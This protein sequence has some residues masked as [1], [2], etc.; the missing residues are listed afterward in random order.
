MAR[1]RVITADELCLNPRG[2]RC[3]RCVE[4]CPA[5]AVSLDAEGAPSVDDEACTG[6]G[7][8][9]GV[10]DA[11]APVRVTL[12][13]LRERLAR[14]A[15][16]GEEPVVACEP[17]VEALDGEP[18]P[19]VAVV[20]CL[21]A[22]PAELWAQVLAEG[23]EP[24]A[25]CDFE[26]CDACPRAGEVAVALYA[27]AIEQAQEWTGREVRVRSTVPAETSLVERIVSPEETDRRGYLAG[28]VRGVAD[29]A[30][31]D[32]RRRRSDALQDFYARRER[33]RATA[34]VLRPPDVPRPNRFCA[35]GIERRVM[36]PR[37]QMLLAA[38]E[39]DPE[40]ASRV[41][42]RLT[43]T[44]PA[45][46]DDCLACADA[47]PTGA[48]LPGPDDGSLAYDALY[49]V[50]CGLCAAACPVG[51]VTLVDVTAVALLADAEPSEAADVGGGAPADVTAP[52]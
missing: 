16:G 30:S 39:A 13:D 4:V 18:A 20:P 23:L 47:C 21:A 5:H 6:C 32:Y 9:V 24:C 33:L 7:L 38:V 2:G 27:E 44:D 43:A 17:L 45:L 41:A 52:M 51:A 12:A 19:N 10:C 49:C 31:G 15:R 28:A 48:R 50:G 40:A 34:R 46:C 8:C 42:L 11:F 37:R 26:R 14:T 25:V 1:P 22:L 29:I 35:G 3:R 36:M